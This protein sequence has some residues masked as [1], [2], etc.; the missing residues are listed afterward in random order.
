MQPISNRDNLYKFQISHAI[1]YQIMLYNW[2]ERLKTF[3]NYKVKY[4]KHQIIILG[5]E[6]INIKRRWSG[7]FQKNL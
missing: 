7:L 3:C 4:S 1:N 6:H 5:W 2:E